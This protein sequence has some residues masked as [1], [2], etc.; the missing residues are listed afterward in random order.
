MKELSLNILDI[1]MNSVRAG[2]ENIDIEINENDETL[3][4]SVRDNGRGMSGELLKNVT[5]PFFTTRTTRNV[6]MGIPLLKLAA[7]QTGG[8]VELSS[9]SEDDDRVNHGTVLK[10][11]FYKNTVDYTPMGDIV[12]TVVTLIQGSPGIHWTFKHEIN[13]GCVSLDTNELKG[14]IGDVPLDT[15]EVLVWIKEYLD[16]GYGNLPGQNIG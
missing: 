1:A 4:F 11:F 15:P 5:D 12:S 7:M 3:V 10:A 16:E 2:A 9:V 14:V 13:G 8:D 6:G